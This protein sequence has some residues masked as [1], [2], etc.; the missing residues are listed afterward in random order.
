MNVQKAIVAIGLFFF[1]LLLVILVIMGIYKLGEYSYTYGYS[2]VSNVAME[3]KPGRDMSI[4]LTENM[5][6][7]EL[8]S[9]LERRGLIEDEIIFRIQMKI[10]KCEDKLEPGDYVLNTSMTPKEMIKVLSG[11]TQ[12]EEE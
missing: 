6:T 8:A 10:N 5:D 11:E 7:K 2:I 9:L 3:P 12:E 4:V 1:R